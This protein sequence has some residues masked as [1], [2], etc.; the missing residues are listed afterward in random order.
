MANDFDFA[1]L[2]PEQRKAL[3]DGPA[4]APPG[5]VLPQFDNP[6][7]RTALGAGLIIAC[8]SIC[9]IVVAIRIYAKAFCSRKMDVEDY[10]TLAALGAYGGFL[11]FSYEILSMAGLY[12]NQWDIRLKDLAGIIYNVN[13]S[14]LIYGNII[15]LLKAGILFQWVHLF[16][17]CNVRNRFW[18]ICHMAI[19]ANVL[20]YV[21]CTI[22]ENFSCTP[23]EKIWNKMVPGHCIN[24]PALIMS[25]GILNLL[26]DIL[27]FVLPQK[28]IWGL[29][30]STRKRVG[31]VV[32]FATGVFG[33]ICGAFRLET[34]IVALNS[35]NIIY[36]VGPIG[37]WSH[38]EIT[39][40]FLILCVPCIPKAFKGTR[41]FAGSSKLD[42]KENSRHGLPSWYSHKA[43][44]KK[45]DDDE[46]S[47]IDFGK[48]F[49]SVRVDG[50]DGYGY[51]YGYGD[52]GRK[53]VRRTDSAN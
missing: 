19:V 23:R 49:D 17:P 37:L 52:E 11:Y 7:N 34:T 41:I 3:L 2:T 43:A 51:G 13:N 25:S 12:V 15:M 48:T 5:N 22:V 53:E 31:V 16:V 4:L 36:M 8:A 42:S 46:G 6:P 20:F 18:W 29:R 1:S 14:Y 35:D 45:I 32:I 40:G 26:S 38:G 44:Q 24:N 28:L 50:G 21:A 10:L 39:A 27:I 9:I 30:I 47:E 33:C